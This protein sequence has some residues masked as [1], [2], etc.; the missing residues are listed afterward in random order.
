[1]TRP[2]SIA[3]ILPIAAA[4][5]VCAAAHGDP[6][7]PADIDV[8]DGD[9]IAV[10][11]KTIRLVGFDAPELGSHAHCGIERMLAARSELTRLIASIIV[12]VGTEHAHA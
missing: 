4:L 12:S 7:N 10:R 11:G 1:M 6:L 8:I 3:Q 5:L 9:T 2:R